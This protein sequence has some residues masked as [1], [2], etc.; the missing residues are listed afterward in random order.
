MLAVQIDTKI[1]AKKNCQPLLYVGQNTNRRIM[2]ANVSI[3]LCFHTIVLSGSIGVSL[4][5][6]PINFT[7]SYIYGLL[8]H[9][10]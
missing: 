9:G 5:R 4:K 2:N 1:L 10:H 8:H 7:N 3:D 6:L